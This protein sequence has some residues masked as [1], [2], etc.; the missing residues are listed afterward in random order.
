[1]CCYDLDL[2]NVIPVVCTSKK[3]VHVKQLCQAPRVC[4]TIIV[5]KLAT[6]NA[7]EIFESS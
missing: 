6:T 2:A 1:M 3:H 5:P 4:S 7:F